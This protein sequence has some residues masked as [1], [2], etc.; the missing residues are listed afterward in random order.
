MGI[1]PEAMV[2]YLARLGWSHGD[3]EIFSRE[4]LIRALRPEP[5]GRG[6]RGL[7]P[8]EAQV[9][10]PP[11]DQAAARR[12]PR[13]GSG[14]LPRARPGCPSRATST[15]SRAWWTRCKERAR[16]LVEMA[17]QAAFY[18]RPP[19]AYDPQATAKF[20]KDAGRR[21]LRHP[22]Q[23]PRGPGG[24]GS[25]GARGALPR[26]RRRPRA[27]ARGPG[28]AHAH[29][30]DRQDREPVDLRGG[31]HARQAGDAR[32]GSRPPRPRWRPD[33]EA[34]PARAPRPV[35]LQRGAALPGRAG[36]GAVAA[37]RRARPRRWARPSAAG[38]SLTSTRAR[39]SAPA[40]TAEIALA[41]LDLPLTMVDDLRELS[42]G[43]WE[44]CT[45]EEIRAQP[46]DPYAQWVRDPVRV[47]PAGRRAAGRGAGA[48]GPGGG[49]DR[50]R[51]PE[52][53]RR[54]DRLR[55]AA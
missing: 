45:V 37:R 46:G 48:R 30:A 54:A 31:E 22:D 29:R 15:G 36:R 23:A 18:L 34:A 33:G 51:A 47:P 13:R 17:E 40:D 50:G 19:A 26:P 39:S 3:Q 38:R 27:Q 8:R 1:L 53:R 4:D 21:A 16:T 2:N 9:G 11:V 52:R 14:A 42:L 55:T 12:A 6:R 25:A 10:L 28:A 35:G 44:G 7:R 32:A 5:R 49:A 41:D 24:D 20:W 43:E